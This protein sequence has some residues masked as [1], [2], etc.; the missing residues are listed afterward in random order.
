MFTPDFASFNTANQLGFPT[1]ESLFS[2]L[3]S[4][5]GS[6]D[7]VNETILFYSPTLVSTQRVTSS[8]L[9]NIPLYSSP[10]SPL[11]VLQ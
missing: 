4:R 6:P 1:S 8:Q 9:T 5:F 11:A 2:V 3:L 7:F 10:T